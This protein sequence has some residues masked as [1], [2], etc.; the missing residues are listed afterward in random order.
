M[1]KS[2]SLFNMENDFD[3]KMLIDYK[4]LEKL[5]WH[6][7]SAFRNFLNRQYNLWPM[8]TEDFVNEF[9]TYL[10]KKKLKRGLEI[11]SG[12]G[13]LAKH[14]ND[15]GISILPTDNYDWMVGRAHLK[16]LAKEHKVERIVASQA[17]KKY[18]PEVDFL[19][20]SWPPH[21]NR[22][23]WWLKYWSSKPIFYIGE[24]P[25]GCTGDDNLH[26]SVKWYS[27][28]GIRI[29]SWEGIH[30]ELHLGYK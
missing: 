2:L 13:I 16:K 28:G 27:A 6:D 18:E 17:I 24:Y 1:E 8:L 23:R 14:L 7:K 4:N 22:S 10:K 3:E 21:E 20:V 29:N 15:R 30:D 11:M 5:K 26:K 9:A 19:L 25:N 12:T